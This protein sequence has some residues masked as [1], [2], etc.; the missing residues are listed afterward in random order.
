MLNPS[1]LSSQAHIWYCQLDNVDVSEAA[2]YESQLSEDELVRY[3]R[4]R[5]E[6][7]RHIYLM[8]H[9]ML[10]QVLTYYTGLT[11]DNISFNKNSYGRPELVTSGRLASLRFNLS[12]T[13]G[14][15]AAIITAENDCGVDVENCQRMND[16][17]A[18]ASRFFA[19][20][21]SASLENMS[22]HDRQAGFFRFWTLKEAYIKARGM[23]LA[24]PLGKFAFSVSNDSN[25]TVQFAPDLGD[26][27]ESWQFGLFEPTSEHQLAWAIRFNN[28]PLQVRFHD[29]VPVPV[30]CFVSH[31]LDNN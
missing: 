25:I 19:D 21:E 14:L 15:V 13:K 16:I 29:Y 23:G 12:H 1:D 4:F 20:I 28:Q 18:I 2:G 11:S 3:R 30:P 31:H 22:D 10:R 26:D 5:F 24:I 6:R 9:V 7:D 27:A 8:A 17:E